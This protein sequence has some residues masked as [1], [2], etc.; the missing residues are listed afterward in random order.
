MGIRGLAV[1][2]TQSLAPQSHI[3][4]ALEDSVGVQQ[5]RSRTTVLLSHGAHGMTLGL[6]F[7]L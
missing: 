1:T 4:E 6:P 2:G 5:S 3:G 7:S